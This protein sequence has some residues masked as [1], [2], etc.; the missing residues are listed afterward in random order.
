M[1]LCAHDDLG[2]CRMSV[3][4]EAAQKEHITLQIDPTDLVL[5]YLLNRHGI[6]YH[7]SLKFPD[8]S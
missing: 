2:N 8:L 6:S 5:F 1:P 4:T 7:I 3:N